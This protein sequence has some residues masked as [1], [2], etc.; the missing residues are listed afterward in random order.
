VRLGIVTYN[1]AK[2]WDLPTIL[3]NLEGLGYAGVE[4]RTTHRHGVE[5]G[6]SADQRTEVRRRFDRSPVELVGL[7]TA[8]EFHSPDPAAVRK[9]I[10]EAK[11]FIRLA[12]DLGAPGIKVRP[13][14]VPRGAD[15]GA[16]LRQIGEALHQVAEFG[17]GYGVEVRLEVHGETTQL[18]PNI[19]TILKSAAQTNLTV[20][21]NSN[22][23]DVVEGSIAPSF[24][25]VKGRIGLVHL[26]DMTDAAYP[27]RELF[28][29]LQGSG[30]EGFTLAEIAESSDPL[31]V[32]RYFRALWEAYQPT[33]PER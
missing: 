3:S 5:V 30:F 29:S 6:L 16:T 20:C 8:C 15:L 7:G 24:A 28:R 12:H 11:E 22:A 4:L 1:I 25:L 21:W 23:T 31:R 27:W 19:A 18:L 33:P 10:D 26:H 14:G 13:N 17:E 2:D 9:N 32:L